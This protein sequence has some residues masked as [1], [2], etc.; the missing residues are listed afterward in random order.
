MSSILTIEKKDRPKQF[1]Y[2]I[3]SWLRETNSIELTIDSKN[4]NITHIEWTVYTK[5]GNL[6]F[7]VK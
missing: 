7:Q 1:I 6:L 3:N 4:I 5:H 2:S